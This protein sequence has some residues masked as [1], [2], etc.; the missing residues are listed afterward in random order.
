MDYKELIEKKIRDTKILII[1]CIFFVAF[2]SFDFTLVIFK[3]NLFNILSG[4]FCTIVCGSS[5][6]VNVNVLE[7]LS[8]LEK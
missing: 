1:V 4:V 2:G 3:A 5:A 7:R 6:I 8:K